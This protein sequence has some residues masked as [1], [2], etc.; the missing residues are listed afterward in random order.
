MKNQAMFGLMAILLIG[1]TILPAMSQTEPGEEIAYIELN[2]D[3]SIYDLNKPISISGQIINFV[4]N[5]DSILDVVEIIFIDPMGKTVSTSGYDIATSG[6]IDKSSTVVIPIKFKATPDQSG[7]FALSTVLNTMLFNYGTYAIQVTTY[8]NGHSVVSTSE[9]EISSVA[10]EESSIEQEQVPIEFDICK[11]LR[12]LP[13]EDNVTVDLRQGSNLIECSVDSNFAIGD[14][15]VIKGKID[16]NLTTTVAQV[17]ISI[18]YAKPMV[19]NGDAGKWVTTTGTPT[20]DYEIE[21]IRDMTFKALPEEDGSFSGF[22]QIHSGNFET[23]EYTI[24]AKYLGHEDSQTVMIFDES[25]IYDM[26]AEFILTTDKDEYVPGEIVQISGYITNVY[27][28]GDTVTVIVETPDTSGF[29]CTVVNECT[30]DDSERKIIPDKGL[31]EHTFSWNYQLSSNDAAIG[32][33][34]VNAGNTVAQSET[35]FF[36]IEDTLATQTPP[37]S[38]LEPSIAKKI[39]EKFN[40]I[41][42]SDILISLDEKKIQDSELAPRVIQGSLFTSAR[43]QESDVNVQVSTSEGVCVIGQDTSCLVDQ[44][45]R[46]PGAIYEIVTIGEQNYKIRYSGPDVRLEKFSILP[47]LSGIPIDI[48]DWNVQVMKDEQPTRFYYKVSYVNLE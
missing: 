6:G 29:N 12:E 43:G 2:T 36:V 14:I 33:Y 26:E 35:S 45:T 13:S 30:A 46:K 3:K 11:S 19:F 28:T 37:P 48:K 16:P 39:I 38:V 22:F 20:L 17:L 42:D 44:S 10:V 15:I 5:R 4:S 31:T 21:T 40:R 34:T 23:A 8:Q 24:T 18:P 47:E 27:A 1:G 25:V 7:N 41:S 9:F 32:K